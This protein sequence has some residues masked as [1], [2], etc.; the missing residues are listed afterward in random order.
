[1]LVPVEEG[2]V[3]TLGVVIV[4]EGLVL[5]FDGVTTVRVT[6]VVVGFAVVE[7]ELTV[8]VA[9]LTVVLEEVFEVV[10]VTELLG[11]LLVETSV[12]LMVGRTGSEEGVGVTVGF[13]VELSSRREKVGVVEVVLAIFS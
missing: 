4:V 9:G 3:V 11:T 13:A 12:L 5:T 6:V 1:M 7:D 2:R 8:G 10:V